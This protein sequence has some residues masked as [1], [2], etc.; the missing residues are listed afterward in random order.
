MSDIMEEIVDLSILEA[1][2][3]A[4]LRNSANGVIVERRGVDFNNFMRS[5]TMAQRRSS[6]KQTSDA[7]KKEP[8]WKKVGSGLLESQEPSPPIHIETTFTLFYALKKMYQ[9]TKNPFI[10]STD[11]KGSIVSPGKILYDNI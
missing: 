8:V 1:L 10:I 6:Q 11:E 3:E 7:D 4:S 2:M 5:A 9:I